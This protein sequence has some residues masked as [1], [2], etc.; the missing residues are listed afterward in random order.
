M[1]FLTRTQKKSGFTLVELLVVIAIMTVLLSMAG[2]ALKNTDKGKGV[3]S[4][5]DLLDLTI[6]EAREIAKGKGTWARVVIPYTP[7]STAIDSKH[8]KFAAVMYWSPDNEQDAFLNPSSDPSSWKM[9][10][11]GITFPDSIFFSP[12]YSTIVQNTEESSFAQP[13]SSKKTFAQVVGGGS[14][15]T[16]C[17]YIEFDNQG[18]MTWPRGATR[19][20][21]MAGRR[22]PD[23]SIAPTPIDAD[24]RPAQA[25]GVV[26]FPKG[27]TSPMKNR[28]QIF[29]N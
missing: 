23:G 4:A 3:Q 20:V 10:G 5:V 13:M 18:R 14:G 2:N 12:D 1:N 19:V 29:G 27:Q 6:Q 21:L 9:A 8:L 16:E 15:P 11:N 24:K 17:Y 26:V 25:G 7:E 22:N 28:D